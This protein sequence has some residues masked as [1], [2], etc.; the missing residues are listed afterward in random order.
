[1]TEPLLS[2]SGQM[3]SGDSRLP[4]EKSASLSYFWIASCN[5]SFHSEYSFLLRNSPKHVSTTL[6]WS[7]YLCHWHG[8]SLCCREWLMPLCT[9]ICVLS[10]RWAALAGQIGTRG[11]ATKVMN[12][13]IFLHSGAIYRII[14]LACPFPVISNHQKDNTVFSWQSSARSTKTFHLHNN[15]VNKTQNSLHPS[16]IN[17]QK[18]HKVLKT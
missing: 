12:I 18:Y 16:I 10:Q 17:T 2:N 5:L 1:M 11:S 14:M 13:G 15:N 4:T 8:G 7:V 3:P 9:C 6:F